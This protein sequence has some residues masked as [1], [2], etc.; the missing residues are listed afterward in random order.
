MN[1]VF[2]VQYQTNQ[3]VKI[4]THQFVNAKGQW[5]QTLFNVA[6]MIGAVKQTMAPRFDATPTDELT[7]HAVV[8][9][10]ALEPDLL[11]SEL[12][13]GRTAKT[14]LIIKSKSDMDIDMP[15]FDPANYE[16]EFPFFESGDA[17]AHVSLL[18]RDQVIKQMNDAISGRGDWQKYTPFIISGMGK[19]FFLKCVGS[20]RL[21]PDLQC[22][23][24]VEAAAHGRVLSFDFARN[25]MQF[26][27]AKKADAFLRQLMVFF[28]CRM[29][30]GCEVDGIRFQSLPFLRIE[31]HEAGQLKFK[32]WLYSC[33]WRSVEEMID[34]YVR[35][36]NL[37]FG[38]SSGAP[39][40]FLFDEVQRLCSPTNVEANHRQDK[41]TELSLLLIRLALA[42]PICLCAGTSDGNTLS[43]PAYSTFVPKILSLAA[44]SGE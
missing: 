9:G 31:E 41:H 12:T 10:P 23:Q 11:L 35:L 36:T 37:A 43:I 42:R 20:Q 29:F 17:E 33:W 38:V 2:W 15:P 26:K 44:L 22:P 40:V 6:D 13:A 39:L 16:L 3:P 4:E 19:T 14:A 27:E 30:D 8:D 25:P 18:G 34:E 7:L 28:L 32:Q 1:E 5:V 24:L 21:K